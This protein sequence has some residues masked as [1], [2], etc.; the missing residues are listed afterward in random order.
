[1]FSIALIALFCSTI[2]L[3]R[4]VNVVA[5]VLLRSI[6]WCAA[7]TDAFFV[8]DPRQMVLACFWHRTARLC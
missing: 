7:E 8:T 6:S 4:F 3:F 5:V 2:N 1:M